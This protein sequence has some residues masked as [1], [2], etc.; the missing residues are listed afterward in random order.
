MK[1][2]QFPENE[3]VRL[4]KLQRYAI[5]DTPPEDAFDRITRIVAKTIGVPIALVT[6]V[7]RDRQWFKA[8]C[9]LE[10]AETSRDVAFCS[11]A[12][13][14]DDVFVVEDASKD[15]RFS[16]N[17]LV[18]SDPSIRFYAGA[19]LQTPDGIKLGTLCAIDTQPRKL[20][21]DHRQ[22]LED[23]ARLVVDELE[24]RIAVKNAMT[25]VAEEAKTLAIRDEFLSVVS[26]ELRTPLTSIRGSLGLLQEG[27]VGQ[28]PEQAM[29]LVSIAKRNSVQLIGLI[30][31]LLDIQK[32]ESGKMTFDFAAFDTAELAKETCDNLAG[33]ASEKNVKISLSVVDDPSLIGDPERIRQAL[34]NLISN[35]IKFSSDEGV[36]FVKL[37]S[38]KNHFCFSVE[39]NGDGIHASFEQHLFDKFSQGKSR[40]K[41]KGTGLG[42]AITK[43]IAEAHNGSV[44]FTTEE[45]CGSTFYLRIPL[46]Q[47]L[48]GTEAA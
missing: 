9:G 2:A 27:A 44:T 10:A 31:D 38:E 23:L 25:R 47:T 15:P 6:L 45:G 32:L 21:P 30:N 41:T 5:L 40:K 17:P 16:D 35:A 4:E 20:S 13:L 36:V 37:L 39:D 22:L 46:R 1:V 42:L 12:I 28:L 24:L 7:D 29:E 34:T 19:P 11:H 43:T 14:S 18:T 33:Y 26:H 8:K 48:V 3:A